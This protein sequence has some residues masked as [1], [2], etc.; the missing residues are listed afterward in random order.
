MSTDRLIAPHQYRIKPLGECMYCGAKE[1][2]IIN[3]LRKNKETFEKSYIEE[4]AKL[5]NE[6]IIP[7]GLGGTLLFE[8]SSCQ[9]C[10]RITSQI[11]ENVMRGFL[12]YPRVIGKL[13][14]R[15]KK[16]RPKTIK[17]ECIDK[18]ESITL[19][20][21][22]L[23]DAVSLLLLP[24]LGQPGCMLG[25]NYPANK[26]EIHGIHWKLLGK[27]AVKF[28]NDNDLSGLKVNTKL[29]VND[30]LRLLAKIA[31][32]YYVSVNGLFPK[33]QSPLLPIIL[34]KKSKVDYSF[35]DFIGQDTQKNKESINN[36]LHIIYT[37]QHDDKNSKVIAHSVSLQLFTDSNA[38]NNFGK[39][40]M[41]VRLQ[42][43]SVLG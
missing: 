28:F 13:P 17:L 11:E 33:E 31:Y 42:P 43:C 37:D 9:E 35:L 40:I 8:K 12:Y 41:F 25:V 1:G 30:F 14:T 19:R 21:F 15:N 39:Y 34:G 10:A 38:N 3:V 2:Q 23:D 20:D 32:G 29:G 4:Q 5:S 24:A 26:I 6:H 36:P 27:D 22:N 16:D 7:F 18:N